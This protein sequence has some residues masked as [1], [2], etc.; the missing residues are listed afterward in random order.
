MGYRG[1]LLVEHMG[2]ELPN[3]FVE[4]YKEDYYL[5]EYNGKYFLNISSKFE[6][7]SHSDI[8]FDLEE[9][10]KGSA[11]NVW[12]VTLWEDGVIYRHNLSTGNSERIGNGEH[13]F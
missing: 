12:A 10:L 4:K 9:I 8:I 13:E 5:G 6:T 11:C 1:K 2:I 3:Y 7:K